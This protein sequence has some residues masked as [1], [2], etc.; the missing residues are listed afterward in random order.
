MSTAI[1]TALFADFKGEAHPGSVE[2]TEKGITLPD[3]DARFVMLENW[4]LTTDLTADQTVEV[5]W[6]YR[7][8]YLHWLR[9]G[10]SSQLLPVRNLQ[11]ICLRTKPGETVTVFFS[12]YK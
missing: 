11:D 1:T 4:H 5:L 8:Q 6:G 3:E 9:S 7:G 10:G 12:Y 2:V